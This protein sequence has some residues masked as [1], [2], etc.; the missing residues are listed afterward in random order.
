MHR[1]NL[2]I[3]YLLA[4]QNHEKPPL[5]PSWKAWYLLVLGVEA[6]LIVLLYVLTQRFA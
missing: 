2:G 5:L 3:L 4:M 1:L 6:L